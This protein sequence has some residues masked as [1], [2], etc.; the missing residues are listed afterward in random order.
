MA[1]D[2]AVCVLASG[3]AD[4]AVL[5]ARAAR[6][7]GDVYPLFIRCGL[8]WEEAELYW[9]RKF[10]TV[11]ARPG[12]KP[13]TVLPLDLRRLYGSNHWSFSRRGAPDYRS[14]DEEVYLPGRNA[15][16]LSHAAVFC[17]L[18]GAGTILL[19]TLKGNPFPDASPAFFRRMETALSAALNF[20]LSIRAPFSRLSKRQVL[21]LGRG[22]PLEL[23]FSCL[24]PRGFKP[25]GRCNKCAERDKA[26]RT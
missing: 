19:G 12:L 2:R 1:R 5:L 8:A 23:T 10:L 22:F 20:P 7:G 6:G 26:F 21:A 4:S 11:M 16:L 25:C 14:R 18:R 24:K 17:S 3:G 9:L 15:L 13:L